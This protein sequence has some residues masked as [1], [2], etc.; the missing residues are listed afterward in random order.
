MLLKIGLLSVTL[1]VPAA[2]SN[3]T[4]APAKS[5]LLLATDAHSMVVEDTLMICRRKLFEQ[6]LA[7][8]V[9]AFA[10]SRGNAQ[11]LTLTDLI[12]GASV[13]QASDGNFW[14]IGN[15][16][17]NSDA[18]IKLY[19]N[20]SQTVVLDFGIPTGG[21]RTTASNLIEGLDGNFY[22]LFVYGQY[23]DT[24]FK[25]TPSGVLTT[26]RGL[27][28]TGPFFQGTNGNFYFI[29]GTGIEEITPQGTV[30]ASAAFPDDYYAEPTLTGAILAS[31]GNI[32]LPCEYNTGGFTTEICSVPEN[33]TSGI[34][35]FSF[36]DGGGGYYLSAL[37]EGSDGNLFFTT[38]NDDGAYSVVS[39][40]L[41]TGNSSTQ[42]PE[43]M[44]PKALC[45]QPATEGSTV[46]IRHYLKMAKSY[47]DCSPFSQALL[48]LQTLLRIQ[49]LTIPRLFFRAV[50]G[51][52]TGQSG[53]RLNG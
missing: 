9:L 34:T 49:S 33:L 24:L 47:M 21:A 11:T 41:T 14:I 40:S 38:N 16:S 37:A 17:N 46:S 12:P 19:P 29:A 10:G 48:N 27:E 13:I 50:T 30:V 32:Y 45:W 39:I 51:R 3:H 22:G 25:L 1:I 52:S 2:A 5:V 31:D 20:G 28:L 53:T 35:V 23:P 43:T 8:A 36:Y 26:F 18:I 15:G 4:P 42:A 7:V 6:V 44:Q